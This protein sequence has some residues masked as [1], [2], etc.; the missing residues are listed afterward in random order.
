[1]NYHRNLH[2]LGTS[3]I[4]KDSVENVENFIENKKPDIVAIELDKKRFYAITSEAKPSFRDVFRMGIKAFLINII[5]AY[6]EKKLGKIVGV[7]PGSEM[8]KAIELVKKNNLKLSLIDQDIDITLRKLSKAITIRVVFRFIGDVVKAAIFRKTDIEL[9]D[10]SKVPSKKIIDN[11]LKKIKE[12]YP[13]IF[14]ALIE[15]RNEVMARN[16]Y[17]LMNK[18]KDKK[19]FAV[20]G[21]GHESE[22]ISIIKG[23]KE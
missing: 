9:F 12:R 23:I 10:V 5:G 2:I 15:E 6:V 3:H 22:I 13:G 20:V 4:S 14:N 11:I 19:I 7:S 8:K 18:Y 16:L 1:M 21:A 17:K